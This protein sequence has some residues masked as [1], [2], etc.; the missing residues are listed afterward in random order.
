MCDYN[1]IITHVIATLLI[2]SC[3]VGRE[4]WYLTL[5]LVTRPSANDLL[6]L[7]YFLKGLPPN[8]VTVGPPRMNLRGDTIVNL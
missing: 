2:V 7:D 5:F 3:R 4:L 8:S 6:D 1:S